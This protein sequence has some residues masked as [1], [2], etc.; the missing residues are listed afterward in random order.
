MKYSLFL[1]SSLVWM[2]SNVECAKTDSTFDR[3]KCELKYL[4]DGNFLPA[5]I[6]FVAPTT[7]CDLLTS[8]IDT[9]MSKVR[10]DYEKLTFDGKCV[11]KALR[12][13]KVPKFWF[14]NNAYAAASNINKADKAKHIERVR[15]Q[16]IEESTNAVSSCVDTQAFE[17]LFNLIYPENIADEEDARQD[18]CVRKYVLD[19]N[20]VDK[21]YKLKLNPRS[22]DTSKI[23]C[24]PI[25]NE[26]RIQAEESFYKKR[27][28]SQDKIICIRAAFKKGKY[29]D[30]I[31]LVMVL[32]GS[33][34]TNTQK[35]AER[36]KFIAA[37][38][39]YTKDKVAC[40]DE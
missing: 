21:S 26:S 27:S 20:L 25:I 15:Q 36:A 38:V 40:V 6:P 16:A 8:V 37:M 17:H 39:Q 19:N 18:Y 35:E 9:T 13:I 10:S 31:A 30:N 23:S 14:L 29:Y 2:T 22:L 33:S 4:K 1:I 11:E 34:I 28:F 7:S 24:D 32:E 3:S 12:D 5:D